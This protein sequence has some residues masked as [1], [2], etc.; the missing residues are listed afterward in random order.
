MKKITERTYRSEKQFNKAYKKLAKKGF[1]V[2]RN[3]EEDGKYIVEY[4]TRD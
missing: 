3:F 1:K 4:Q 2:L